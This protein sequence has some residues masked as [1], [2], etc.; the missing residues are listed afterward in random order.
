MQH[1]VIAGNAIYLEPRGYNL[2]TGDLVTHEW[3]VMR[4]ALPIPVL[5]APLF[6]VARVVTSPC[7]ILIR[8]SSAPGRAYVR[9]AGLVLFLPAV[10]YFR[11][12]GAVVVAAMAG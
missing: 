3:V 1:P 8:I 12:K 2:N 10:W 6:I 11:P 4:V 5:P 9:A 7:G